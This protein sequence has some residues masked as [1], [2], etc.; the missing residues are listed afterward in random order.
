[1]VAAIGS[2]Y[3]G[4]VEVPA[5]LVERAQTVVVDQ[6][7]D[8]QLESGDLIQAHEGREVR[9][10]PGGGAGIGGRRAMGATRAAGH[11][12]VRVARHRPMGSGRATTVVA[13]ARRRGGYDEVEFL[14]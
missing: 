7:A 13:A 9:L 8:A 6:L 2:N 4:R 1:M 10:E 12:P 3:R 14:I 11:H 5:E